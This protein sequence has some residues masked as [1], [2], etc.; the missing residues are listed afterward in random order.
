MVS[1]HGINRRANNFTEVMVSMYKKSLHGSKRR[2][3]CNCRIYG[4]HTA[5]K[6]IV[7]SNGIGGQV[8]VCGGR[9]VDRQFFTVREIPSSKD[10]RNVLLVH[11]LVHIFGRTT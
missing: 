11:K 6:N 8:G 10:A 7:S 5:G 3:E 9:C 1:S 4:H 2:T